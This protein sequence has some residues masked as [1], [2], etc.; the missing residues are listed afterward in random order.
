MGLYV[1]VAMAN[2]AMPPGRFRYPTLYSPNGVY[3]ICLAD[4][5][6]ATMCGG[7]DVPHDYLSTAK[8]Y[9]TLD[10][11]KCFRYIFR[12]I[13]IQTYGRPLLLFYFAGL[14]PAIVAIVIGNHVVLCK[15]L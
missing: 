15:V 7:I 12:K 14:A 4:T 10:I 9:T 8:V 1:R 6:N 13:M 5:T 2:H 11:S 3:P